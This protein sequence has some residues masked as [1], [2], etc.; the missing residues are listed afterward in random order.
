MT[1]HLNDTIP[2]TVNNCPQALSITVPP[3][4]TSQRVTWTEPTASVN[5]GMTLQ[6]AQSHQPGDI[7]PVGMT[8]VT[9]TFTDQ[10]GNEAICSFTVNIGNH[11]F[12]SLVMDWDSSS[13]IL[14]DYWILYG[15]QII[16]CKL[17]VSLLSQL[18]GY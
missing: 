13:S 14:S 3:G 2:P 6:M 16:F 11:L 5:T 8:T 12:H 1:A 9:Y 10:V 7:F 4:T 17:H 18:L 15:L